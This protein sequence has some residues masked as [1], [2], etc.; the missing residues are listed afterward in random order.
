MMH[1][2]N[3][4]TPPNPIQVPEVDEGLVRSSQAPNNNDE[5]EE[6]LNWMREKDDDE[7]NSDGDAQDIM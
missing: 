3:T 1:G 7:D 2:G 6:I 5:L 4:P